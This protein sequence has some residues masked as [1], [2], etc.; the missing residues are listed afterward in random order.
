[1]LSERI[2]SWPVC[3]G[4]A[5]VPDAYAQH[6]FKRMLSVHALVPDAYGIFWG[7]RHHLISDAHAGPAHQFLTPRFSA[8]ISSWRAR[9]VHAS[10]PYAHAQHA[11]KEAF[12]IWNFYA[13]AEHTH[14][15]LMRMLRVRTSSWL[16]CSA[17]AS[18]PDTHAQCTY[19]FL[20][21]AQCTHHF[22]TR[23]LRVYKMNIWKIGK[24]ICMLSIRER[25]WCVCSVCASFPDAHAQGAHQFLTRMLSVRIKVGA[26]A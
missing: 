25:N 17:Y 4:Y 18:V 24:L 13:Y 12:Q 6:F 11:L 22:L 1:M 5:S 19:Q 9:S 7:A 21:H 2:S 10:V 14:K 23:M 15:K 26:C 8:C 16:I 3:S 20:T